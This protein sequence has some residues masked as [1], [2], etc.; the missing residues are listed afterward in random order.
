MATGSQSI[1]SPCQVRMNT[2]VIHQLINDK[3]NVSGQTIKP[4]VLDQH[5]RVSVAALLG[6]LKSLLSTTMADY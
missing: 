2:I 3:Y 6:I 5:S 1:N 4:L